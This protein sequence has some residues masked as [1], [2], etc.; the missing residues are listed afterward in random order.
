MVFLCSNSTDQTSAA[1]H[2]SDP[3]VTRA[4][5]HIMIGDTVHVMEKDGQGKITSGHRF[6][7][8]YNRTVELNQGTP[9]STNAND[10]VLVLDGRCQVDTT[11]CFVRQAPVST[12]AQYCGEPVECVVFLFGQK[13]TTEQLQM[14]CTLALDDFWIIL[15][16]G[17][18]IADLYSRR[19][20]PPVP[21]DGFGRV[22]QR[23]FPTD[24]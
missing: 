6:A 17:V 20:A 8:Q 15:L 3:A 16:P 4:S 11:R 24:A 22:L 14:A 10:L 7:P 2:V 5:T 18:Q 12:F 1:K 19:A 13:S 21:E 9:Y 23:T